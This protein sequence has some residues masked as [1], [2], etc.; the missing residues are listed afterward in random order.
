MMPVYPCDCGGTAGLNTRIGLF[1]DE[2]VW[3]GAIQCGD[4]GTQTELVE[5]GQRFRCVADEKLIDEAMVSRLVG[6]WREKNGGFT[7]A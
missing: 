1:G 5:I 3:T 2:Q 6:V 7:L 4:C